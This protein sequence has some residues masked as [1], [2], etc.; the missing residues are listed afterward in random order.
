MLPV[1]LILFLAAPTTEDSV[2][3]RGKV[4]K[5]TVYRPASAAGKTPV[6][7]S[8]GDGGWHGFITDVAEFLAERGHPVIGVSSLAYLSSLSRDGPIEPDQVGRDYSEFIRFA[9]GRTKS[10]KVLLAGW[11]E[12]AGLSLLAAVHRENQPQLTGLIT[13]GL[14]EVS[15]LAWRWRDSVIYFTRKAPNEKTFNSK[16]YI[17]RAAPVALVMMQ[18]THDEFMPLDTAR[19]IY[20]RAGEPKRLHLIEA[21]NH[22]FS[23]NRS[24]FFRRLAESVDWCVSLTR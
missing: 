5:V 20:R 21:D 2:S 7:L 14:P 23:S 8:S 17:A 11:S 9:Q 10:A 1:T 18:S 6:V 13:L 22:R 24:E 12:G 4:Q 15:E 19:E 3:I 16:D